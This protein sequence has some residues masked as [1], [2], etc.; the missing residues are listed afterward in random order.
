[1]LSYQVSQDI[2]EIRE[3]VKLTTRALFNL[4]ETLGAAKSFVVE[5]AIAGISG[6]FN[7]VGCTFVVYT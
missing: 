5:P 3:P 4:I 2:F 6:Q 1:M 7:L